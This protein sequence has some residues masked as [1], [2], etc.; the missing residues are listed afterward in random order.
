[1][2]IGRD[3]FVFIAGSVGA[4]AIGGLFLVLVPSNFDYIVEK[5]G[6]VSKR[7]FE[8]YKQKTGEKLVELQLK[9]TANIEAIAAIAVRKIEQDGK[10]LR[11]EQGPPGPKGDKGERGVPGE[12]AKID[13]QKFRELI[14]SAT[15]NSS[16]KVSNLNENSRKETGNVMNNVQIAEDMNISFDK[17][18]SKYGSTYTMY[19]IENIGGIER[20]ICLDSKAY[21]ID[22]EGRR[23]DSVT[24]AVGTDE[25]KQKKYVNWFRL[26]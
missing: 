12:Q 23:F 1:M 8:S 22:K 9:S 2:N 17:F 10:L 7:E 13:E 14:K 5:M 11:G 21:F 3:L 24:V 6:G 4:T 15:S 20:E 19:N 25:E 16:L 18:F 26:K